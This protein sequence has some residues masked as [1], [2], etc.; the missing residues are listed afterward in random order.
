M[1]LEMIKKDAKISIP[2]RKNPTALANLLRDCILSTQSLLNWTSSI[3]FI[4]CMLWIKDWVS[5]EER[6]FSLRVVS[7]EG[8]K[9]LI[10][11]LLTIPWS[12]GNFS[13]NF[14]SACS[15]LINCVF[16]TSE[17]FFNFY[18][19]VFLSFSD[20]SFLRKKT[21][22][23]FLEICWAVYWRLFESERNIPTIRKERHIIV[24]EKT[25]R[26]LYCQRLFNVSVRKYFVFW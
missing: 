23:M 17:D 1:T 2:P 5:S 18:P 16:M 10:F 19:M 12:S 11:K 7:K 20:K 25:L 3:P 8:G 15:E 4:F 21:M 22:T 14:P 6:I 24:T 13:R 9:G 26:T